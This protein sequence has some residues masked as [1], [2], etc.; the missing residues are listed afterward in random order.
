[1]PS[2]K[3]IVERLQ[4][5][6][7]AFFGRKTANANQPCRAVLIVRFGAGGGCV[8]QLFKVNRAAHQMQTRPN[9]GRNNAHRL[10][11]AKM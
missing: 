2:A 10:R 3:Q 7:M 9:F 1:M 6:C 4:Q 11:P 8:R 5:S